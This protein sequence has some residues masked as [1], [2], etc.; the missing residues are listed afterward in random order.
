MKG[1]DN[2][3]FNTAS[4]KH[5]CNNY[6]LVRQLNCLRFNTA[7]GKHCCNFVYFRDMGL[8]VNSSFNTASGKHCCNHEKIY[9]RTNGQFVS[10]PQAVSTVATLPKVYL[11][12]LRRQPNVSI[13]QAVSTVATGN[14]SSYSLFCEGF[15]YRKR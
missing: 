11:V 4:G 5:C 13:P 1:G 9:R 2:D 6:Q 14:L 7:S 15:Q 8:N 3:C 12:L 10:I